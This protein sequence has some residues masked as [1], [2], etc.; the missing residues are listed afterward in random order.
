MILNVSNLP[1]VHTEHVLELLLRRHTKASTI[2]I[3]NLSL[4]E[5]SKYREDTPVANALIDRLLH[6][7]SVIE[8]GR[9]VD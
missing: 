1:R 4:A 3:S 2:I 8:V 9:R 7:R 6:R 5:F